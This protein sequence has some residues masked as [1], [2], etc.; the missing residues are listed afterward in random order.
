MSWSFSNACSRTDHLD[1][2]S[3][4]GRT[5]IRNSILNQMGFVV[6]SVP[7]YEWDI[8]ATEKQRSAVLLAKIDAAVAQQ[9]GLLPAGA[10]ALQLLSPHHAQALAAGAQMPRTARG[11]KQR[12]V[13]VKR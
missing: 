2:C 7:F 12:R 1:L 8:F 4:L 10:Q 9:R 3:P 13:V 6:A 11:P 5:A